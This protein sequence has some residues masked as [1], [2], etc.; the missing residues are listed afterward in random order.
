MRLQRKAAELEPAEM[1]PNLGELDKG[2]GEEHL[3]PPKGDSRNVSAY[4]IN[5]HAVRRSKN[6]TNWP[7]FAA[8]LYGVIIAVV[9]D[10]EQIESKAHLNGLDATSPHVAASASV[11]RRITKCFLTRLLVRKSDGNLRSLK[12]ARPEHVPGRHFEIP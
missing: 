7:K 6:L 11:R 8:T 12:S 4:E 5:H 3:P 9:G 1:A 10:A 2:V